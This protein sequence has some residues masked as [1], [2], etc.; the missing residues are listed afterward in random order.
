MSTPVPKQNF[1][2]LGTPVTDRAGMLTQPWFNFLQSLWVRSGS[3][4]GSGINALLAGDSSQ[5][6][7]ASTAQTP[8]EV[9]PLAQ[10]LQL[11]QT[12]QAAAEGFANA[13]AATAQASAEAYTDAALQSLA[14]PQGNLAG[15]TIPGF[16]P[17]PSS[18]YG[19]AIQARAGSV[20]QLPQ[21]N[22]KAGDV[23]YFYGLGAF[24]IKPNPNQAIVFPAGGMTNTSYSG[25]LTVAQGLDVVLV[26]RGT[27]EYD[28]M[29]GSIVLQAQAIPA[30]IFNNQAQIYC[31]N[32][33]TEATPQDVVIGG[34]NASTLYGPWDVINGGYA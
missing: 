14:I 20:V 19:T 6:F 8:S 27:G 25:S 24:T 18:A 15:I 11:D 32:A 13:V 23:L 33:A 9:T 21:I 7:N 10:V 31:G 26:S 5:V 28:V 2:T 12:T 16:L 29:G 22:G 4:S 34:G 3:G 30:Y 17:L 1:P